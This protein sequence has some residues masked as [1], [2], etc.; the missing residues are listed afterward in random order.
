MNLTAKQIEILGIVIAGN[1]KADGGRL[2]PCDLDQII[3][4]LSYKPTKDAIQFS[5]RNLIT[6]GVI[7]KAG[8]EKRRDRRRVLIAP[9]DLGKSIYLAETN[10][11]FVEPDEEDPVTAAFAF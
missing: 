3:E 11:C 4:R 2:I 7:Q 5:I 1:G 8:T 6:K 10:P 9:T